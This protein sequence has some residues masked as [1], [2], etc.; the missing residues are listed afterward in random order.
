V[1][2]G[3]RDRPRPGRSPSSGATPAAPAAPRVWPLIAAAVAVLVAGATTAWATARDAR[4]DADQREELLADQTANL[5]A[6]TVQ[7]L[8]AA[9]SG[10]SGLPDASGSVDEAAFDAF[11]ARAV[12][13][14]PFETLAFAP[15]VTAAERP[16]FEAAIGGPITDSPG[17]APAGARAEYIPVQRVTPPRPPTASLIGFDL[18]TDAARATAAAQA[19]DGGITVVTETVRSRPSGQPAVF[20]VHPVY[21]PGTATDATEAERRAALVG[22]VTTGVLGRAL[23][24][25]VDTQVTD[26]LGIRI[27]D[28]PTAAGSPE[29][30][31][32]Q[33]N[34]PPDGGTSVERIVAG[35]GWRITVDDHQSATTAAPWSILGGAT[36][37]AL[38]LAL[39]ALRAARHQREVDRHVG[40]IERIAG[41]GRSLTG[42]V[43]VD[44]LSRVVAAEVPAVLAAESAR[45]R[46]LATRPGSPPGGEEPPS[47]EAVRRRITDDRGATVASLD[48]V[49]PPGHDVDDATAAALS[50]VGEM[51][52][53]TLGRARLADRARRDAISSRLLAGLAEAAA[54]AG[55]TEQVARTLVEHAAE[56]PGAKTTHI[57]LLAEQDST[58]VVVHQG[59][60][61]PDQRVDIRPLDDP[62]PLVEAFRQSSPVLL[63][64]LDAVAERFPSV[65]D[66]MRAAG[67]VAVACLPL[68]DDDG[69]TFGAISLSW[70]RPQRFDAEL[71]DV[72][73]TTADLCASS[74]GRARATDRAQARSSALATLAS[75]LSGSTSF[76]EVG[77]TIVEHATTALDA[78]F[79]LVGVVDGDR[80]HLLVPDGSTLDALE[81]YADI[82]LHGDF[83]AL[84]A[85]RRRELVT[86]SA[87][88]AVPDADI[89]ADLARA[90]LQAGACAPLESSDGQA[91]GVFVVLWAEPPLFDRSLLARISTVADLCA[92]SAER[93]RLFDAEHRVRRDLQHSVLARMPEVDGL[94]VATR[95]RPAAQS[96]GMGG[97]WYDA[98]TLEG[99]RLCLVVGDVS[100][101][102]VGAV[103]KMTQV[104]SVVHTLV[105]GGMALPEILVRTSAVMQR[106]DLGYATVL[107]AVLDPSAGGLSYV[108]A[109][110]PPALVRRPGGTV[111]TLTGGRHSVLGIDLSPKPPGYV[112]F[113]GGSTVVLYTDG[114]VEQRGTVIDASIA[115]LAD[116]LRTAT[117]RSADGLAD[118]LLDARQA[119]GAPRDDI[120]LV[121]ARN[122]R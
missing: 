40:M 63:G 25:A 103:A 34:P 3:W 68:V 15:L 120:A 13:A 70:A 14:S 43:S 56:V 99:G 77:A 42:A 41:L 6:A 72:L 122:V 75:H 118:H 5:V 36:A 50:T 22:Y 97:D 95:Y 32:T 83:P 60:G 109:G 45:F 71:V 110:H 94:E 7:Q 11:A 93:S 49:W 57:G 9:V 4:H 89:A 30:V 33:S 12:E 90:G 54:T 91:I 98:I 86:F 115:A 74:L 85:L 82:D 80:F 16:A 92:Q 61:S 27:E 64:D 62:W 87:L 2:R 100:G 24:E 37:L 31:L 73:H 113:P 117:A 121:V 23:F 47:G 28:V 58:L 102:G 19:R 84:I 112:A 26:P 79:A 52:R 65:V 66:G 106:D 29:L 17:G 35:R 1:T 53:Q 67:M 111:D 81:P 107:V 20:V 48:V 10:G 78:D 38:A 119:A 39:V 105:A 96:V 76:D 116:Q 46:E 69:L 114:L 104:R 55:T 44:E 101:H 108:T 59:L 18:A 51:C 88:D 21:L 8:V